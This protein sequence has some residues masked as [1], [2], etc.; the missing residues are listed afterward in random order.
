MLNYPRAVKILSP[1]YA[2]RESIAGLSVLIIDGT[3]FHRDLIKRAL[4]AQQVYA[5]NDAPTVAIANM[6]M[7]D[8]DRIDLIIR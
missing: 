1:P 2:P 4:A 8:V 3:R 7:V 5:F 6:R